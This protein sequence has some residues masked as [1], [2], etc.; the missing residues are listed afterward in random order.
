MNTKPIDPR[1]L[2][3]RLIRAGNHL[4]TLLRWCARPLRW[5]IEQLEDAAHA[6]ERCTYCGEKIWGGRSCLE[7]LGYVP[8]REP[9]LQ[10]PEQ[11]A[12]EREAHH[13]G[14]NLG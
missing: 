8:G 4:G 9:P 13:L 11:A 10:T 5:G 14:I 7:V 3:A 1:S 6:I 2:R 12:R